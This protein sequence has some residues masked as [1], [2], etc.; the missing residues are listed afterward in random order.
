MV[1][2][3]TKEILM[4]T[5]KQFRISQIAYN[6]SALDLSGSDTDRLAKRVQE[7]QGSFT[8]EKFADILNHACRETVAEEEDFLIRFIE[9]EIIIYA[10][11]GYA[12]IDPIVG[13]VE[14]CYLYGTDGE[15][16]ES[17][18]AHHC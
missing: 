12:I 8:R 1:E 18:T 14:F 16:F 7:G 2:I 3:P 5:D 17:M 10:P 13:E 9:Q 11:C 4:Q 15:C 6:L